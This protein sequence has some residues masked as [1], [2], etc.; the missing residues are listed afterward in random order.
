MG[1]MKEF[2]EELTVKCKENMSDLGGNVSLY[3]ATN[4]KSI[5]PCPILVMIGIN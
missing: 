1:A 3:N 2:L 4:D 5:N